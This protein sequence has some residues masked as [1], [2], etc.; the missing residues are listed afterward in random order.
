MSLIQPGGDG[1]ERPSWRLHVAVL[2]AFVLLS[3]V[4]TWPTAAH[5]TTQALG[6][7]YFDRAQ[8]IWN[9]W[10]IKRALLDLH[11]NPFATDLLFY[12]HGA[13]LYFQN[14]SLP[15]K[16]IMIPV[17]L[18][19]GTTAA[20]NFGMMLAV[21]L[22]GYAGFRLVL[23]LTGSVPGALFGGIVIGFNPLMQEWLRGHINLLNAQWFILCTEFYLRAFDGGRRRDAL[24]AGLFFALA[25]LTVG[26]Y[27][28]YLLV[29]FALHL[30]W[31]VMGR[32]GV[33]WRE[34]LVA[35]GRRA[36]PVAGW[37]AL[38]AGVIA[39]P[40]VIGAVV[41]L[42][43]GMVLTRSPLDVERTA[44]DSMD[45]LSFVV[46]DRDH[47]LFGAGPWWGST[48][49]P[50]IHEYGTIGLV[51]LVVAVAG[52]WAVRRLPGVWLWATLGVLGL[53][54]SLGPVLRVNGVGR[55]GD[56]EIPM[57]YGLLQHIP[58]FSIMR[59]PERY[60]LLAYV[61]LAVLG[62][63]G[64]RWMVGAMSGY[65]RQVVFA[66]VTV[67]LLIE[68]P[69]HARYT[70]A[71]AA[72]SSLAALAGEQGAGALLELPLTQHG[73]IETPRMY[74]QIA[75]GRPIT[76]GYLSRPI[77]DPYTQACSPLRV[78]NQGLE[79]AGASI[80]TPGPENEIEAI[81]AA[82]GFS[83]IAVYKQQFATPEQL[84]PVPG[85]VLDP[86][87]ELA[88]VLGTVVA[89]DDTATL[90]RL[91]GTTER[92]GLF[93]QE[94]PDWHAPETS[95]GRPFQWVNGARADICVHS[96]APH[97]S[98]LVMHA[99]SFAK[100]RH[101]VVRVGE[102]AVLDEEVPADGAMHALRTQE[103]EW[104]RGYQRVTITVPEGSDS[105]RD[106]DQGS[107]SR[108][109]SVGFTEVTVEGAAG[110]ATGP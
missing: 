107:D 85:D 93:L 84:E 81:L 105:P 10:W 54:M 102:Q 75:H 39:A 68:L 69:F 37:A 96:P 3:I 1:A 88:G 50:A 40:Y 76:S 5:F 110:G 2:L 58:P 73:W 77:I 51:A 70:E 53:L 59:A 89:D 60:M 65:R 29:F 43:K 61:A 47:W 78:F 33:G 95:E 19:L 7:H 104:P 100:P 21:A 72:P 44:V 55:F 62:G 49:N 109:L 15:N 22:T 48:V 94:G 79:A 106:L 57:L 12:P 63:A 86:L 103:I 25:M 108:K 91:N 30:V 74:N 38:V 17:M 92:P 64:V 27:E 101:L 11:T 71:M 8:S 35:V 4:A 34:R 16:L 36:F 23:Y 90:Y 45:L 14:L 46:P 20:Y 98:S 56:V 80:T 26:Y 97:T 18:A 41:S 13:D 28:I 32:E 83:H 42:G 24:L 6:E 31:W 9:L 66:A 99:T 87:Q 67:L 82:T 52:A